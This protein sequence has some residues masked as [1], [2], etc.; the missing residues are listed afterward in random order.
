MN[1]HCLHLGHDIQKFLMKHNVHLTHLSRVNF[2][3]NV[4]FN[5]I[6]LVKSARPVL[7]SASAQCHISLQHITRYPSK[8]LWYVFTVKGL[9]GP[10]TE[11]AISSVVR[12]ESD[13]MTKQL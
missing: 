12:A 5:L 2:S 13:V 8:G 3:T 7:P 11:W 9:H 1:L 10:I 6:R 4:Q